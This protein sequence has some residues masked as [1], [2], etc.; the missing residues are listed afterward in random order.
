[1]AGCSRTS[2]TQKRRHLMEKEVLKDAVSDALKRC[3]SLAGVA[4]YLYDKDA[5]TTQGRGAGSPLPASRPASSPRTVVTPPP[6][7]GG[8]PEE[9]ED[10]AAIFSD[11]RLDAPQRPVAV[12]DGGSEGE[13]PAHHKPW[14]NGKF[15]WYCQSPAADGF[16][17]NSRG[18][19]N[20]KPS[21]KWAARQEVA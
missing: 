3:A 21:A 18:Y 19:C 12:T 6:P 11:V 4:R 17:R 7:S 15:G 5:P 2:A 10:F 1:M 8:V 14:V 16:K 13:C 9:P 20:E